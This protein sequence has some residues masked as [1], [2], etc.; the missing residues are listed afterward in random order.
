[1]LPP[2]P[3]RVGAAGL[4]VGTGLV[5][6]AGS[7]VLSGPQVEDL[8]ARWQRYDASRDEYVRGLH[9]QLKGLQVPLEPELMRKEVSRLN[10]QLE[11]K[12]DDCA[13]ARRELAA[14]RSA[15]DEALERVQMLEQQVRPRRGRQGAGPPSPP[16]AGRGLLMGSGAWPPP[17]DTGGRG[18]LMGSGRGLLLLTPG[19]RPPDAVGGVASSCRG[20]RGRRRLMRAS[21][22]ADP[23]LQGRL[24]VGEGRQGAGA[25]PH[26]RAGEA[27]GLAAAP[28]VQETG[29]AGVSSGPG[30][31]SSSFLS[32]AF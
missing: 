7:R 9:A 18:L 21:P 17:P 31:G 12:M 2:A 13:E 25:E 19:A 29:T 20:G 32:H 1:M 30:W 26:P 24:H 16:D 27:G 8:N 23:R 28:G 14:A 15:R 3:P 4:H 22:L 6:R 5:F 10:A 11:E